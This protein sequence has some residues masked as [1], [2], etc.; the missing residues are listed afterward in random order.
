[1]RSGTEASLVAE[2]HSGDIV[3]PGG[4]EVGGLRHVDEDVAYGAGAQG[5]VVHGAYG[6]VL[7]AAGGAVY[8]PSHITLGEIRCMLVT[9]IHDGMHHCV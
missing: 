9:L 5:D 4:V 3:Y 7:P 6:V 1:M 8:G 2:P